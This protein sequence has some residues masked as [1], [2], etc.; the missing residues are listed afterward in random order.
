MQF[1]VFIVVR[2]EI[3]TMNLEESERVKYDEFIVV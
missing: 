3:N 2:G 1:V